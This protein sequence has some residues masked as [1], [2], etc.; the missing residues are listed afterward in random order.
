MVQQIIKFTV[1]LPCLKN[2][3][4]GKEILNR[5]VCSEFLSSLLINHFWCAII[6]TLNF[7]ILCPQEARELFKNPEVVNGEDVEVGWLIL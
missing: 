7:V 3:E 5:W 6:V 4:G 1:K 2:K